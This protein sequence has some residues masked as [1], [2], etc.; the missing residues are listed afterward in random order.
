VGATLAG[1]VFPQFGWLVFGVPLGLAGVVFGVLGIREAPEK[2]GRRL[3]VAGVL[4]GLIGPVASLFIWV[5]IIE[6]FN[7]SCC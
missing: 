1:L 2:G 6:V 4:L 3:A 7:F 5:L